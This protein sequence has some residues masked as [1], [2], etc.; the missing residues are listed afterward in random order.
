MKRS[1]YMR[2]LMLCLAG[3]LF[4][5]VQQRAKADSAGEVACKAGCAAMAAGCGAYCSVNGLGPFCAAECAALGVVCSATCDEMQPE[6][7]PQT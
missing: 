6:S 2:Y 4:L 5:V 3:T 7:P 1:R